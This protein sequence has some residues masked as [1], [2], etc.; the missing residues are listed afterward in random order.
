MKHEKLRKIN[1]FHAEQL[2]YLMK[3]L[4]DVK[5]ADGTLL[6]R[7]MIVYGSGIGDGNR[8]SH[9][10]LPVLLAGKGHET[11]Q[12]FEDTVTP[13]D[14]RDVARQVLGARRAA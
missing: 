1:R 12:E 5:E 7:C 11:Y 14:D 13:F 10:D 3:R 4:R 2:A 9:H 8:H 6:D